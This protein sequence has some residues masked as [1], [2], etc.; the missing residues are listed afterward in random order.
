MIGAS[1]YGVTAVKVRAIGR[2]TEVAKWD[3]LMGR[4]HYLG[5]RRLFGGGIRHVAED[6]GGRWLAL[7]GW[8]SGSLKVKARD[9]WI[10]WVPEQQFRRLHLVACNSR[11]LILPGI[12]SQNLASRVLSLSTRRLSA[13]MEEMRGHPLLLA[14]TFV[15]PRFAGTCYR[16]ANWTA[17]GQTRGFARVRGQ[18]VMHGVKK[19]LFVRPLVRNAQGLLSSPN[20]LDLTMQ[21]P[22][23]GPPSARQLRL[24]HE[25]VC[26]ALPEYRSRRGIRHSLATLLTVV[27]AARVAGAQSTREIEEF[28]AKYGKSH[29]AA[30]RAFRRSSAGALV[31]PSRSTIHRLLSTIDLAMID[32]WAQRWIAERNL[33]R[34]D[35]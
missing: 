5:F 22:P 29:L 11:F 21:V 3:R 24:L 33:L 30:V 14:E 7:V 32:V 10:G 35:S 6:D 27:V 15:D 1:S 17:L 13:D 2:P 8:G 31:H 12:Q 34:R 25:L 9:D 16:A 26:D 20:G 18:W 23:S 28:A 19:R 4:Y